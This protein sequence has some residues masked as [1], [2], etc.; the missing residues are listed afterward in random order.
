MVYAHNWHD[1]CFILFMGFRGHFT[2]KRKSFN[3]TRDVLE[4]KVVRLSL[5][6]RKYDDDDDDDTRY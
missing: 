1:A 4:R 6:L 2:T 3:V 5:K